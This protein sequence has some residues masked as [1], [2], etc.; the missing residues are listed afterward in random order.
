V[1][2]GFDFYII[3]YPINPAGCSSEQ[4][5]AL[6]GKWGERLLVKQKKGG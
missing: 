2:N 5:G 4:G 6:G 3:I 1:K